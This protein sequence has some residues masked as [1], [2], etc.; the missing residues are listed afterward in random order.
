MAVRAP[1]IP[2]YRL[3]KS[4]GQARVIINRKHHY[5]GKYGSPESLEKYHRLVAEHIRAPA[6]STANILA[7]ARESSLSIDELIFAYWKFAEVYLV[8]NGKRT[9]R[10]YHVRLALRP[11]RKLY[12]GTPAQEFG[13][14]KLKTVREAMITGGLDDGRGP[15]R[16][17]ING[18]VGIIKRMFRWA[19]AEELVPVQVHQAL[20]TVESIHKGRDPRLSES[21]KIKPA[22][23]K[24]VRAILHVVSPQIRTMIELQLSTGMRPDEVTI[25][26]PR[27]IDDT[28][29]VWAYI[30]ESHKMEHKDLDRV[31]LLGPK[32]Q[33]IVQ[34][35]L[36]REP[37]AYLFSPREV[38][39]ET[40]ARRRKKRKNT[41][42]VC[43]RPPRTARGAS[44]PRMPRDHYDDETYCQAVER[45]CKRA[46]VPKWTPGQLRHN[47][48]T[49]IR[50]KYGL[51]AARLVLGHRSASTTEIYAEKDMAEAI[52][53][54]KDLG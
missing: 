14:R 51:E 48:G 10:W 35:W 1:R 49:T 37:D 18:H 40:L 2:A 38:T 28:G 43:T 4:S 54:V 34:P 32:S 50:H 7:V 29:D 26:R 5:L 31:I 25:M 22:P 33:K 9:D 24:H 12:G 11:L 53:I 17:Y 3:H 45:A 8:K 13:P 27:D 30:P 6:G 52:R 36:D 46:G 44:Y 39:E 16:K 21:R 19:V 41:G 15:N 20:E 23:R 42:V 47:A